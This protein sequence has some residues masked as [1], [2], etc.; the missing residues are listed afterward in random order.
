MLE[1]SKR[2]GG[3]LHWDI[4]F[5]VLL[6][7]PWRILWW[8]MDLCCNCKRGGSRR[9]LDSYVYKSCS[10]RSSSYCRSK[11]S[12][13]LVFGD[14]SFVR[15]VGRFGRCPSAS[16]ICCIVWCIF[17]YGNLRNRRNPVI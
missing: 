2:K 1:K 3:G 4:V 5:I 15:S 8:T 12:T 9:C 14:L 13:C 16:T 6:K 10:R 7:H 11:R 17:I